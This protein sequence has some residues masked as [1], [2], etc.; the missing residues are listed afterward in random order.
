MSRLFRC[1]RGGFS[2]PPPKVKSA[3]RTQAG[4][5]SQFVTKAIDQR[6]ALAA[7]AA[8]LSAQS[9]EMTDS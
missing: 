3:M 9:F 2:S 8:T 6:L 7:F 1:D 5:R 4:A